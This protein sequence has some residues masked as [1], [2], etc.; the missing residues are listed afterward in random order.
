MKKRVSYI[1]F[2]GALWG[3]LEAT[4]GHVLHFIPATIA[5]S[6]MFPIASVILINAYMTLQSKKD[7]MVIGIIAASI[8]SVNFFLPALSIYK[9]INPMVSIIFEALLVVGVIAVVTHKKESFKVGGF[10][11]AS[12]GWRALFLGYMGVQYL[13]SGNLA[14]YL[15]DGTLLVQF[16]VIEGLISALFAYGLAH[17]TQGLVSKK[18]Q[19]TIRPEISFGLF[20]IALIA[21]YYL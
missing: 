14:P 12:V 17:A 2:Y 19:W 18:P 15:A 9:T 11:G 6:V 4:I 8:K 20:I 5:G 21:T 1:L 13:I 7:L 16:L 3:L 10:V